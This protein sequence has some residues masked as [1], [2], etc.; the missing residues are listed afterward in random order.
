MNANTETKWS[1]DES[2][3]SL[4]EYLV[5]CPILF[6][7]SLSTECGGEGKWKLTQI[8]CRRDEAHKIHKDVGFFPSPHVH[9]KM[10]RF[11]SSS[12]F[13]SMKIKKKGNSRSSFKLN[14][15]FFYRLE[16]N[17]QIEFMLFVWYRRSNAFIYIHLKLDK[18]RLDKLALQQRITQLASVPADKTNNERS[19]SLCVHCGLEKCDTNLTQFDRK[20]FV[21][22]SGRKDLS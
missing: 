7:T 9:G 4:W 2:Q 15:Y 10:S 1:S 14:E 21:L 6:T 8:N 22:F 3:L 11:L 18:W 19:L 12:P 20:S 16:N 17:P 13:P 5:S